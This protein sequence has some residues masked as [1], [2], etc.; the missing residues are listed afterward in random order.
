VLGLDR[1]CTAAQI[2]AAW[3][4]LA[5]QHHPDVNGG[6]R[7]ALA[8]T[9]ELNAAHEALGNPARRAEYDK[10]HAAPKIS[11][12]PNRAGQPAGNLAKDAHLRVEEFLRGTNLEV[13]VNDIG[14]PEGAEIYGL[15]VPPGT[16]PGTRFKIPRDGIPGRSFVVVRVRA[17]PDFRFKVR[18]TDLRCDLRVS[19]QRARQGG[20]E[21]VRGAAG[22]FLRVPIPGKVSHGEIIRIPGEGLP[23]PRGGRGDLLVRITYRP[24][25]RII[26][27]QAR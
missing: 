10:G 2:Q 6:S 5:K 20:T 9:Q 19:F 11:R 27:A 22:N 1:G 4:V 3:R 24:E 18:G 15:V 21:R 7:E 25:I 17:R 14:N 13:R 16:A 23:R 8:R 26:R 12:A